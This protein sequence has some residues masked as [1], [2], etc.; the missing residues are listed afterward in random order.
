M[1]VKFHLP[2]L[3]YNYPLNML[4]LSLLKLKPEYFREGVEIASFFGEF[5]TSLWNGGRFSND[6]QCDSAFIKGVIRNINSQGIPIRY[7]YT[8]PLLTEHD[9]SDAYCNF[10]MRAADNGRNEVLVVSPVLEA[11]IRK[12]YPGF[13]INSST[14]K[15][16]RETEALNEE[17]EK[18]YNLVV[19]DYNLNNRF[20]LLEQIR[21]KE[22][23][24]ILVN[25]C[26]VPNC[27]RRGEHYR[28]IA[29]QERIALRNRK[30]PTDKKIPL[31]GWHCEYGDKNSIYTIRE[32]STFVSPEA[33]WEIYVPMGYE[34]FKIEGRTANLF[35]LLDT[36][37]F[38]LMKPEYRE[39][40]RLMLLNNLEKHKVVAVQKPKK[41]IW[42]E[43][44]L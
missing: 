38:Y 42:R 30:N 21:K 25:A 9:L 41:G 40:A 43:D 4:V 19:L 35:Q 24:E 8:N 14:C 6:D 16:I 10:C 29:R 5:P 22:K 26:C 20:D 2:G 13:K 32:Y 3:R 36:Y 11:Y 27:P 34:N 7:T 23:C 12:E 33:I 1:R 18:D 28:T 44:G 17:L 37:C 39:E 31:P 15:E